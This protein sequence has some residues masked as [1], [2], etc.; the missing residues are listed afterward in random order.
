MPLYPPATLSGSDQSVYYYS[1]SV[2]VT[3]GTFKYDYAAG[4]IES[5]RP[6]SYLALGYFVSGVAGGTGTSESPPTEAGLGQLWFRK[7]ASKTNLCYQSENGVD[8][9]VQPHV[10][11]DRIYVTSANTNAAS[12][13]VF[14]GVAPTVT[15][16]L[17]ASTVAVTNFSSSLRRTIQVAGATAG[18][19]AGMRGAALEYWRGNAPGLGGFYFIS[20]FI[21]DQTASF[22]TGRNTRFFTGFSTGTIVPPNVNPSAR[23]GM[24]GICVDAGSTTTNNT[25]YNFLI[26]TG[27]A[28]TIVNTGI[29]FNASD[30]MDCRV[31]CEPSGNYISMYC[32]KVSPTGTTFA[33]YTFSGSAAN[34]PANTTLLNW[35]TYMQ[36]ATSGGLRFS[37]INTY[38]ESDF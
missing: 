23:F 13:D 37:G 35:E 36:T 1:G 14:G 22:V 15:G 16:A 29:A 31:Y 10:A 20:R 28:P 34:F 3:T 33:E 30:V 25:N 27:S 19:A 38:I 2:P 8:H 4:G 26:N 12:V 7:R 18:Q 5:T 6:G 17:A 9:N 32:G 21:V 11:F 24:F